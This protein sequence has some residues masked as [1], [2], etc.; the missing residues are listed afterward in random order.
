M[1]WQKLRELKISSRSKPLGSCSRSQALTIM[2]TSYLAAASSLVWVALYYLPIGGAIFRIV[3]P[4]PLILLQ[5][6]RGFRPGIEG[7]FLSVFLLIALMGPIRGPLI[8]FPYGFLSIWLGWSWRR[9]LSWWISWG[10]GVLIGTFGF[11]MRVMVLSLLVGENLWVVITRAGSNLLEKFIDFSNLPINTEL[12]QVQ[13]MALSLVVI[14]ELVYVLTL[15]AL[16]FWIFPRLKANIPNPPKLL[17]T[18]VSL[19]PL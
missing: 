13:L 10:Y 6:R 7:V 12:W 9:G 1:N 15:H 19:D 8:M 16:A 4:M 17:N 2:E 5:L 14:Q 18:L 11:L 3:L